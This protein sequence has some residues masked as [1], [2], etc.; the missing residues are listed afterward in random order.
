MY[1]VHGMYVGAY[2][3]LISLYSETLKKQTF[4]ICVHVHVETKSD[5][6]LRSESKTSLLSKHQTP[7]KA[8]QKLHRIARNVPQTSDKVRYNIMTVSVSYWIVIEFMF[9]YEPLCQKMFIDS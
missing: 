2:E 4:V 7:I 1:I 6:N 9:V 8:R 5:N 3:A